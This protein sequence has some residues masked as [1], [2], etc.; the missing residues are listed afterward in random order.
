MSVVGLISIQIAILF[1]PK[2]INERV[3]SSRVDIA[4]VQNEYSTR[5]ER[6]EEAYNAKRR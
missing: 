4:H 5:G 6:R 3:K 2:N 1:A